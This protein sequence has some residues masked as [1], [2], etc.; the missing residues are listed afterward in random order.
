MRHSDI[1][2]VCEKWHIGAGSEASG[3]CSAN[4]HLLA[5]LQ[6][7]AS[8]AGRISLCMRILTR[9]FRGRDGSTVRTGSLLVSLGLHYS[10]HLLF[11]P[12]WP[13][14]QAF[15]PSPPQKS[16]FLR[17]S[18]HG[19]GKDVAGLPPGP[20]CLGSLGCQGGA[21]WSP[22]TWG[23]QHGLHCWV[24]MKVSNKQKWHKRIN[25]VWESL[26]L[27]EK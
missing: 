23:D 22:L 18:C 3:F 11:P 26:K 21:C 15:S 1:F 9:C 13:G 20:C 25:G 27:L 16:V 12:L 14:K 7:G 6:F 19:G 17:G 4:N 8:L 5:V 10:P 24:W 2:C